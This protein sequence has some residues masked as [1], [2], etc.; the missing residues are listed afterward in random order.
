MEEKKMVEPTTIRLAVALTCLACASTLSAQQIETQVTDNPQI[1]KA[2]CADVAWQKELLVQYPMITKACQE[3]VISDGDKWARFTGE[4]LERHKDGSIR[5]TID[6]RHG[7]SLGQFNLMPAPDQRVL[8]DGQR[9]RFSE[10]RPGQILNFYVPESRYALATEQGAPV[11]QEARILP[12]QPAAVATA[13][14]ARLAQ[15]EPEP[16]AQALPDTAGPLP[17]FGA[18]GLLA[19]LGGIGLT[20]RRR[21]V[22][23]NA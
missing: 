22:R 7:N 16:A 6:D 14:P 12:A 15:A 13:E 1:R 10:L 20:L 8:I 9:V 4:F 21:F 23:R 3:V 5:T 17:L 18:T 11:A 2:S 19:L